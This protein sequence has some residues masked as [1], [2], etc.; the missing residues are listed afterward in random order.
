MVNRTHRAKYVLVLKGMMRRRM[1]LGANLLTRGYA[2]GSEM[3]H[4]TH[5]LVVVYSNVRVDRH[6]CVSEI[7]MIS[8]MSPPFSLRLISY[9]RLC[10]P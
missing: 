9:Q 8:V 6:V 5:A 7:V 4:E 3:I 10:L 1:M 2:S